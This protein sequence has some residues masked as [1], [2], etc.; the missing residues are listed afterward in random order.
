MG[1][2]DIFYPFRN[3]LLE[4]FFNVIIRLQLQCKITGDF[5][6]LG[7]TYSGREGV[8]KQKN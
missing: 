4:Q 3:G 8:S 6:F 7:E 1:K 2:F 5:P